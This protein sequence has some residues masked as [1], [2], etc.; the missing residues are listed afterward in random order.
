GDGDEDAGPSDGDVPPPAARKR[1]SPA[2][3]R[4]LILL[5][6]TIGT[7]FVSPFLWSFVGSAPARRFAISAAAWLLACATY[8]VIAYRPRARRSPRDPEGTGEPRA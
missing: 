7:V 6:I 1:Q 4:A 3:T 5:W 2:T 8:L